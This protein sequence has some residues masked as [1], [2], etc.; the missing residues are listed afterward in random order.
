[1][2]FLKYPV[3]KREIDEDWNQSVNDEINTLSSLASL[4]VSMS[5]R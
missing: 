2:T 1:M 5:Q 4:V 3:P